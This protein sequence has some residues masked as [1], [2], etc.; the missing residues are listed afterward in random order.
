MSSEIIHVEVQRV[1]VKRKPSR[2]IKI[3]VLKRGWLETEVYRKYVL[4]DFEHCDP[5]SFII[6]EVM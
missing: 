1:E 5:D 2:G 6:D 3:E 4:G